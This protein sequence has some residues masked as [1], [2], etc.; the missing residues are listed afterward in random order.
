[1]EE[2]V[3]APRTRPDWIWNNP[4]R[5]ALQFVEET[6]DFVLEEPPFLFNEGSVT[7]RVTYWPGGLVRRVG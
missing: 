1:M 7:E 6:E 3:G 5:A 2:V 4:R